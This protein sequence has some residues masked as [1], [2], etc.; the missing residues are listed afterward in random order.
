MKELT[1][2]IRTT[3]SHQLGLQLNV[4]PESLKIVQANHL[5]DHNKQCVEVLSLYLEQTPEP[6]WSEV[7]AALRKIGQIRCAKNITDKISGMDAYFDIN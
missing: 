2:L 7:V 3:K 5:N 4:E 6:S 1:E